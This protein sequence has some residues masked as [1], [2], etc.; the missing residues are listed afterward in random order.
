M[1]CLRAPRIYWR[2]I[3]SFLFFCIAETIEEYLFLFLFVFHCCTHKHELLFFFFIPV[4]YRLCHVLNVL[5]TVIIVQGGNYSC[6]LA[7]LH[8]VV[9]DRWPILPFLF[10]LAGPVVYWFLVG[11]AR[12]DPTIT[13]P[14]K[15]LCLFINIFS[16]PSWVQRSYVLAFN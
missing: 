1:F 7:V 9:S 8:S 11:G 4:K 15:T 13:I 10:C 5:H 2:C 6:L 16:H 14:S 3:S 12:K